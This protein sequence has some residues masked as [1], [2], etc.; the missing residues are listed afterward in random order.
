MR[1]VQAPII[2]V[3]A[4]IARQTPG[5]ISLGQGMVWYGPPP[6]AMARLTA[7]LDD[8]DTHAYGDSDGLAP[9]CAA[10]GDKLAA[11]N[12]TRLGPERRL[13]VT[14]GANMAF[15]HAILAIVDPGD[16]VILPRPYYFNH[17]MAIA[18]ASARPVP[19]PTGPRYELDPDAVRAA[20]TPRTRA[21]VTVSPNNPA[22]SVYSE[23]A[24]REVNALCATHG[25]YHLADEVYEH[26]TYGAARHFSAGSIPGAAG[27]TVSFYSFSKDWGFAGWRVGYV[28][29]PSRL[30]PEVA[31]VQDTV[32]VCPPVASQW[33]A[34]GA[35]EA[36]PSFLRARLA[37]LARVRASALDA[38]GA[39][40]ETVEVPVADGAFYLMPR[41][42]TPLAPMTVVERL[43]REHR[44]AV[45][46]GPAFGVEDGCSLRVSYGALDAQTVETGIGRLVN[47][48]RAICRS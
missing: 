21:I 40:A 16:E 6:Q 5:T 35:L 24:L 3:V 2:P 14:A 19:V 42:R 25:L 28:V 38:L 1:S 43:I 44:V 46:P 45:L 39:I 12:G 23:E 10:L 26:F 30:H 29:M 41:V 47:G 36:G 33:A 17:E 4:E 37:E 31:K 27:H 20:I 22:G 34:L 7:A 18:M 13:M 11:E 9:L 48:L 32:L 15:L 8:P